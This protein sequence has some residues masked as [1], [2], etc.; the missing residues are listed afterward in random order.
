MASL[1]GTILTSSPSL[2]DPHF[3]KT[4]IIIV[5][6]NEKGA[7]GFVLNQMHPRCLNELIEFNDCP[8]LQL[9]IGGP[10]EQEKLFFLHRRPDLIEDGILI[11]DGVYLGGNFKQAITQL[12]L[13]QLL[14]DQI[15]LFVGYAGWDT[16]QLEEEIAEGSWTAND[17][18]TEQIFS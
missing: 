13:N 17:S 11:K 14:H 1:L 6:H 12:K 9:Y 15:R 4:E 3:E 7:M 10:V 5:E 8:P 2:A 16:G 18:S